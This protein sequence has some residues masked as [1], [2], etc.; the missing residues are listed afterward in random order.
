MSSPI[1]DAL[2]KKDGPYIFPDV[3][4]VGE[5]IPNDGTVPA[6]NVETVAEH[7]AKL[8]VQV[9]V[10]R[11]SGRKFLVQRVLAMTDK[12]VV[13]I[14]REVW[15]Y[16]SNATDERG[17]AAGLCPRCLKAVRSDSGNCEMVDGRAYHVM[18][19]SRARSDYRSEVSTVAALVLSEEEKG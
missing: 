19:A 5:S 7:Q 11:S 4:A 3:P 9:S 12:V 1:R 16:D 17:E 14:S 8:C 6:M 13:E 18:C 15:N 2:A 10:L